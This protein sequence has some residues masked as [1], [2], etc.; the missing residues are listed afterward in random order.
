MSKLD[1]LKAMLYDEKGRI[2]PG[3]LKTREWHELHL[4]QAKKEGNFQKA[5]YYTAFLEGWDASRR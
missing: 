5:A 1:E 3:M 2:L 4:E